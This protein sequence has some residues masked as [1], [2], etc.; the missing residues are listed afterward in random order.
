MVLQ[1]RNINMN[2]LPGST[3]LTR[4]QIRQIR[5]RYVPYCKK[6]GQTALAQEYK[7]SQANINKIVHYLS[8]RDTA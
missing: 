3:K 2:G 1:E 5:N 4:Q 8:W 7:V 6:N